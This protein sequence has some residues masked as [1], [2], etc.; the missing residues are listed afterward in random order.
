M[1]T[2]EGQPALFW[3]RWAH[4]P[5]HP[6][7]LADSARGDSNGQLELQFVGDPFLSPGG[8]LRSHLSYESA[9]ILGNRG[10]PTGRDFQRQRRRN[11]LRCQRMNVSG[12]TFTRA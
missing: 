5:V 12:L 1:V 11:P 9:Q 10:L 7:V 3:V 8:I 2:E 6:K 4:R